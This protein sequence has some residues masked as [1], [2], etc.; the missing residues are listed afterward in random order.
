MLTSGLTPA[1]ME[2]PAMPFVTARPAGFEHVD[3]DGTTA[4]GQQFWYLHTLDDAQ[5]H[6]AGTAGKPSFIS[7]F[8][9]AGEVKSEDRFPTPTRPS[10][11]VGG[12]PFGEAERIRP[13]DLDENRE[14]LHR[15]NASLARMADASYLV[16]LQPGKT[17]DINGRP[18]LTKEMQE[19]LGLDPEA[20]PDALIE[21]RV[22]DA[23]SPTSDNVRTIFDTLSKKAGRDQAHR[24]LLDLTH[25]DV[26]VRDLRQ[27]LKENPI[28]KL[29]EVIVE[30]QPGI[31]INFFPLKE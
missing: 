6:Q 19:K 15:Q 28:S 4:S 14:A 8:R 5:K 10:G 23:Y 12:I 31:F 2:R 26:S 25:S 13:D 11:M 21:G 24:I 1:K 20:N 30:Q 16:V 7:Q 27:Y 18:V 9:R 3:P 29:K 22:F 17:K